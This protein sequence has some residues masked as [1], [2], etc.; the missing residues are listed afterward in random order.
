MHRDYGRRRTCARATSSTQREGRV[1]RIGRIGEWL[2]IE[3]ALGPEFPE[4]AALYQSATKGAKH[5]PP[6]LLAVIA[7]L[8]IIIA[9]LLLR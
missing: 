9:F 7:L 5:M 2:G 4:I 1:D 8:A 3:S 6:V